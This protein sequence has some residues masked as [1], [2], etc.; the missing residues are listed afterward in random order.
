[1]KNEVASIELGIALGSQKRGGGG[2][3]E[4]H[5]GASSMATCKNKR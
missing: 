5:A 2:G 3:G 4:N 1:M